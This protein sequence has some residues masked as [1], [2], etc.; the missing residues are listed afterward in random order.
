[1][2]SPS[3]PLVSVVIPAY[4]AEK[5]LRRALDSVW[6]QDYRPLEVIVID[7]ASTDGT[8]RI[9]E[10]DAGKGLTLVR[11]PRNLGECG[12]MNAGIRAA[13][14]EYVAF[15]DADDEWRAGKIAKQM[16]ILAANPQMQFITCQAYFVSPSNDGQPVLWGDIPPT[17]S[18]EIWRLLLARP[19][20]SK[21]CVIARRDAL[22][23]HGGFDHTLKVAGDQDMWIRLAAEG[24]VGYVPEPL[25]TVYDTPGSL[26]KRYRRGEIEMMLPMIRGHVD[27]QR[28]RLSRA[29]VRHI[30]G[31]RYDSVGRNAYA[32]GN[33]CAGVM[34]LMRAALFGNRP[35]QNLMFPIIAAPPVRRIAQPLKRVLG[36]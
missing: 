29:E 18:R 22:L 27:R 6:L 3:H 32:A 2:A 5:T 28:H 13:T 9:A 12:A 35:V 20:I 4:N 34:C 7:D 21:P 33:V 26:M 31:I 1:M 17:D 16:A 19:M 8:A 14:G 15:L 30:L 11:L 25:V 24:E 36:R 10:E 23:A